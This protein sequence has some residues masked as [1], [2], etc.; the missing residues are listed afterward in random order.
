MRD[1]DVQVSSTNSNDASFV[2]VLSA[3]LL[4]NGQLQEFVFPS[5]P[6]RARY[7]EVCAEKQ[8]RQHQQYSA[9]YFQRG[10]GW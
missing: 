7:F 9:R 6:A 1:F 8:L 10:G 5:G 3:T 4:N 2:T